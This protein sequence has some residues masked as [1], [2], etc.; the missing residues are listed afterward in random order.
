M[1]ILLKMQAVSICGNEGS[2]LCDTK[3]IVSF[4]CGSQLVSHVDP[5]FPMVIKLRPRFLRI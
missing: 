3:L 2:S 4:G 5:H 1:I